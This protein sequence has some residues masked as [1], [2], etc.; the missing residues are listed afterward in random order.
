MIQRRARREEENY[1]IRNNEAMQVSAT[2]IAW[3]K[4]EDY[5][6]LKAMFTDGWKLPDTYES[7]Q[8]SAQELYGT[9]TAEGHVVV[10]AYIDPDTFPEWCRAN[11]KALDAQGRMAYGSEYAAESLSGKKQ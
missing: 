6:R 4:A 10:K 11:G 7:W 3:Y 1:E 5:D 2:G 8:A 9:L